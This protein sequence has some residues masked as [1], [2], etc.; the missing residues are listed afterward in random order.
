LAAPSLDSSALLQ[1]D[2]LASGGAQ[3]M[4]QRE[5]SLTAAH[6]HRFDGLVC[7]AAEHPRVRRAMRWPA[8]GTDGRLSEARQSATKG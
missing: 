5:S 3:F 7:H 8:G 6:D 4:T 2:V 1:D